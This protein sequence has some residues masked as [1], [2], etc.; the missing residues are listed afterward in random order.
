MTL[1]Y[2]SE[3]RFGPLWLY[4]LQGV[5][6]LYVW[7]NDVSAGLRVPWTLT[8]VSQLL[9]QTIERGSTWPVNQQHEQQAGTTPWE[10]YKLGHAQKCTLLRAQ[11][12]LPQMCVF[13]QS[14]TVKELA[15][16]HD[17]R[18]CQ[19]HGSLLEA[20]EEASLRFPLLD[21][22][23][24]QESQLEDV[25]N[26]KGQAQPRNCVWRLYWIHKTNALFLQTAVRSAKPSKQQAN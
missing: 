1:S 13:H 20:V 16:K 9:K 8:A 26:Q 23:A 5:C 22:A 10:E 3:T 21:A 18:D 2:S 4:V 6:D 12:F 7:S 24:D 15:K 25:R 19:E 11:R 14:Y 17:R